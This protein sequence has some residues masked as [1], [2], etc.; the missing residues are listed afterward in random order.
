[1]RFVA[2]AI[3]A[4]IFCTG[5]VF[6]QDDA[7]A[8]AAFDEALK[9]FGFTAG[10]AW[11]CSNAEERPSTLA[12]SMDIYN[13]LTQLFGTDRAFYFAAAFGAGSSDTFDAKECD[14]H[15]ADFSTGIQSGLP[16]EGE[17]E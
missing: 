2:S 10:L 8:E 13:R 3:L 16:A 11:Q 5:T 14:R 17:R 15:M 1:M 9:N 6:A 7:S 4:M 12:R